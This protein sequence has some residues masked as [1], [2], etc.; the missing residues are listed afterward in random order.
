MPNHLDFLG[1]S[2][3]AWMNLPVSWVALQISHFSDSGHRYQVNSTFIRKFQVFHQRMAWFHYQIGCIHISSLNLQG[4][5]RTQTHSLIITAEK[6]SNMILFRLT[7]RQKFPTIPCH[8]HRLP[9]I[10]KHLTKWM[11]PFHR[12]HDQ[13]TTPSNWV[14]A[15]KIRL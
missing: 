1:V 13:P 3:I 2:Q 14:H 10:Q 4:E 15:E 9:M 5:T 6:I 11:L 7:F 8:V 12:L